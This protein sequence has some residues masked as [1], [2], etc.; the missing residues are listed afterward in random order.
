LINHERKN[1]T[2]E[3]REQLDELA[4]RQPFGDEIKYIAYH[5][6]GH[7][8]GG[9]H[10]K[11]IKGTADSLDEA[12]ITATDG[13]ARHAKGTPKQTAVIS[14]MGLLATIKARLKA[15]GLPILDVPFTEENDRQ[16]Y[17]F[18][19]ANTFD[20]LSRADRMN[21]KGWHHPASD[22]DK[23]FAG[24]QEA[25]RIIRADWP[26]VECGAESLLRDCA[27]IVRASQRDAAAGRRALAAWTETGSLA[28]AK[29]AMRGETALA[30]FLREARGENESPIIYGTMT[31]REVKAITRARAARRQIPIQLR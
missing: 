12:I 19:L 14:W 9:Y 2:Q 3:Q 26:L 31:L 22:P 1:M 24:F 17:D 7:E 25:A 8:R 13:R 27:V 30:D 21:I 10:F 28:V 11:L 6:A 20:K 18:I 4:D 23:A 29:I 15:P 16:H 5:E